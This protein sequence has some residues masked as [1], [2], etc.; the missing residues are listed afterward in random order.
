MTAAKKQEELIKVI[1]DTPKGSR[2]KYRFELKE[3]EFRLSKILPMGAVFPFDFG[4]IPGTKGGDGDP[5]DVLVLSEEPSFSGC[6]IEC[7]LIGVI[8]AEQSGPDGK[9]RNDR[10]IGVAAPVACI[11]S[12]ST[13]IRSR[14]ETA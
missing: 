3:R 12:D 4:F 13:T 14:R 10:L 9:E 1:V 8:E 11:C 5:L 7:R 6:R 2:N